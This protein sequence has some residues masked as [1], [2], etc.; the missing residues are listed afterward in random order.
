MARKLPL[1]KR[2][3]SLLALY[4]Y[5]IQGLHHSGHGH[6]HQEGNVGAVSEQRHHEGPAILRQPQGVQPT[7]FQRGGEG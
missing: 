7:Q 5:S 1:Q 3:R 6:H 2:V 4:Y